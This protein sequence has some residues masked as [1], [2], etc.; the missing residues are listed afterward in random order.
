MTL[1]VNLIAG[2]GAGKSTN[3]A[4]IFGALKEAGIVC[5]LVREYAKELVYLKDFK[6]LGN[7][8]YVTATQ[9]YRQY[10]V[11]GQVDVIVTDSPILVGLLYLNETNKKVKK[12]FTSLIVE[13]FKAQNNINFYIERKKK[14]VTSGRTQTKEEAIQKDSLAFKL[15]NEY[16]IPF[17][18]IDG[19]KSAARRIVK[20]IKER[21]KACGTTDSSERK[22]SGK[23]KTEKNA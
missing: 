14:Y 9:E 23:T 3:A 21:L 16:D 4:K 8:L 10:M 13:K 15:L 17:T 22:P 7:Q 20:A 1:I 11:D 2:P 6:T 18:H 12:A 19:N 5:E